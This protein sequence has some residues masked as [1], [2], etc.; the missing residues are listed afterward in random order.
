MDSPLKTC[1]R[2]I[3]YGF[4]SKDMQSSFLLLLR[5]LDIQSKK[6]CFGSESVAVDSR[7]LFCV[8]KKKKKTIKN[9]L[10]FVI[11]YPW[12]FWIFQKSNLSVD[13]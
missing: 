1:T 9:C 5:S 13:K 12:Q 3:N 2:K 7:V 4:S 6:I 8:V 10:T 11:I